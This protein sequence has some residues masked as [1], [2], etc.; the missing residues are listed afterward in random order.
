[1][2]PED[3]PKEEIIKNSHYCFYAICDNCKH[4]SEGW[5]CKA[6]DMQTDKYWYCPLYERK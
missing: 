5:F 6:R 2:D 1:M 3:T 4:F